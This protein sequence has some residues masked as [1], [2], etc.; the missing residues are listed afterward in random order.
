MLGTDDGVELMA[1]WW[2]VEGGVFLDVQGA[3]KPLRVAVLSAGKDV[4]WEYDSGMSK[5]APEEGLSPLPS[6]NDDDLRIE[7]VEE[8]AAGDIRF[9]ETSPPAR[10]PRALVDNSTFEQSNPADGLP[11]YDF[12]PSLSD[13]LSNTPPPVTRAAS[14]PTLSMQPPR[15]RKRRTLQDAF[16]QTLGKL[17]ETPRHDHM[18]ESHRESIRATDEN[19]AMH[20]FY[21]SKLNRMLNDEDK[22][23]DSALV[24]YILL[25]NRLIVWYTVVALCISFTLVCVPSFA[26]FYFDPFNEENAPT[27][28]VEGF[29][30][31]LLYIADAVAVIDIITEFFTGYHDEATG[32]LVM[33]QDHIIHNQLAHADFYLHLA[34]VLPF[35][36]AMPSKGW[37]QI[38]MYRRF[39]RAKRLF[40]F[41]GQADN[42]FVQSHFWPATKLLTYLLFLIHVLG[43]SM[44]MI[45]EAEG[46]LDYHL[47]VADR[48]PKD[49]SAYAIVVYD[50]L[51][52]ILGE[53]IDAVYTTNER[54]FFTCTMVVGSVFN[55]VLFGQVAL[56]VSGFQR[57]SL[58]YQ[59]KMANVA[60]HMKSLRLPRD[61][62]RRVSN[63]YDY[64]WHRNQCLEQDAFLSEV[65][66]TLAAEI[67][68]F[69]HR[70]LIH[71]VAFFRVI[72]EP[73]CVVKLCQ[74]LETHFYLPG[75]FIVKEGEYGEEMY[76][77]ASGAAEV[78]VNNK[79][80]RTF[81]KNAFFGEMALMTSDKL[82]RTATIRATAYSELV[83]LAKPK[84]LQLM[85][86][87][88]LSKEKVYAVINKQ[89]GSYKLPKERTRW[90]HTLKERR[91]V[92]S[93]N[94]TLFP[95]TPPS[96]TE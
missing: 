76:M 66:N 15:K 95:L 41:M 49:G 60:E 56:A 88:P 61:V 72:P 75:D 51:L 57:S 25:P 79:C 8:D 36:S 13:D 73:A 63:F 39:F 12:R 64:M 47:T 84:F 21:Q 46:T 18:F 71:N 7:E 14:E 31:T 59:E 91:R 38:A 62:Q 40:A 53:S 1:C 43:C 10:P 89:V 17:A 82:R 9:P 19:N 74:A 26:A 77:L 65:S 32:A 85:S 70:E 50:A 2:D 34:S 16:K 94:S 27:Q 20:S 23:N 42:H 52:T 33:R 3:N 11:T 87:Y 67:N 83:S 68:L 55:A 24:K 28:Q 30:S 37:M 96:S 22:E 54:L 78:L 81:Y 58:R 92:H 5:I 35:E 93:V 80:V 44:Y 69:R 6:F 86:E 4:Q 48:H 45:R 29:L 90:S